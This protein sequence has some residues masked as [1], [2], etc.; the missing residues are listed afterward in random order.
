MTFTASEKHL[1][2]GLF[3]SVQPQLRDPK[4]GALMLAASLDHVERDC[5]VAADL[6]NVRQAAAYVLAGMEAM[7][8][9]K[10]WKTP[11]EKQGI[12]ASYQ[13][14]KDIFDKAGRMAAQQAGPAAEQ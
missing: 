8:R 13:A 5:A 4:Q 11:Q 6:E 1:I 9:D 12:L 10:E 14:A 2:R 7:L 3:Q